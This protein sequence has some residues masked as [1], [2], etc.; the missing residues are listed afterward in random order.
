MNNILLNTMQ[1]AECANKF[2]VGSLQGP[3]LIK[4]LHTERLFEEHCKHTL[5]CFGWKEGRETSR[6]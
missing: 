3:Q 1:L 5:V 6:R 4:N 2:E